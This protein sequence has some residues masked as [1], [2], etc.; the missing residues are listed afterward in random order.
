M[1]VLDVDAVVKGAYKNSQKKLCGKTF[2]WIQ[3]IR[4]HQHL[5]TGQKSFK[6]SYCVARFATKGNKDEHEQ[7][8]ASR[9]KFRCHVKN[10]GKQFYRLQHTLDHIRKVHH[11][12]QLNAISNDPEQH[13]RIRSNDSQVYNR[14]NPEIRKVQNNQLHPIFLVEKVRERLPDGRIMNLDQPI[15]IKD[16]E[17]LKHMKHI[18]DLDVVHNYFKYRASDF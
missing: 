18:Y 17:M 5:H 16:E 10:C 4:A 6:C 15:Q 12:D 3:N 7:R 2:K 11:Q 13:L 1:N 8:H 14:R 9:T